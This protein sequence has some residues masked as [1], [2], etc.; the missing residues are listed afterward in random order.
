MKRIKTSLIVLVLLWSASLSAASECPA[1]P[2]LEAPIQGL[3]VQ[4]R[5]A[6]DENAERVLTDQLWSHWAT[7]PDTRAQDMLDLGMRR[8]AA[9]DLRAAWEAFDQ[10]V[11]YCPDYAEGYNQRAF[12]AFLWGQY[13]SALDDLEKA[14]ARDPDHIAALAGKALTLIGLGRGEEGQVVLRQA[15]ELNPWLPERSMLTEPKAQDI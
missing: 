6:P 14:L 9:F 1:A 2:D 3:M 7:A 12:V 11:A 8:R 10:L 5:V 13:G 15:L 4:L